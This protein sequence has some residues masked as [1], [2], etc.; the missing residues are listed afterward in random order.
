MLEE[1]ISGEYETLELDYVGV[2]APQFSFNRIKGADPKLR[3]EMSSTGEVGVFGEDLEEAYLKA[4]LATGWKWPKKNIFVSVGGYENKHEFLESV[5]KLS[6]LGLNIFSTDKTSRFLTSNGIKNHRV[7]KISENPKSSVLDLIRE[8][9]I[10][11]AINI[12][13]TQVDHSGS[14]DGYLIRRN[15]IDYSVPLITNLQT[16]IVLAS[17]LASK[18]IKDLK[19]KA[20]DEYSN[21]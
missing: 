13:D 21:S 5:R 6:K 9:K 10:E 4:L 7:N 14:K 2:K 16:A 15:C 3:V 18:K 20:W 17:A 12:S 8:G 11:L 1:D 19:I